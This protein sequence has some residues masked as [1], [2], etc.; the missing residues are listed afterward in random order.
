MLLFRKAGTLS[1]CFQE[2]K[3]MFA[4]GFRTITLMQVENSLDSKVHIQKAMNLSLSWL[5]YNFFSKSPL[6]IDKA[7]ASPLSV[8]LNKETHVTQNDQKRG[9]K[10][11]FLVL[12]FKN[13]RSC[14]QVVI[15]SQITQRNPF[16]SRPAI[17]YYAALSSVSANWVC[18]CKSHK[19]AFFGASWM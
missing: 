14:F 13:T 1:A 5:S 10:H 6:S 18:A 17:E 19:H 12:S 2:Q 9:K 16:N 4:N 7:T 15:I 8:C 3:P 11:H